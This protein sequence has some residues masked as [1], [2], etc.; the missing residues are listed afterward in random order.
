MCA[1]LVGLA[2]VNVL[3]V[4]L[5]VPIRVHV[6]TVGE[7]PGCEACGATALVKDRPVVELVDLSC[8]GRPTRLVWHKRRWCCVNEA[9]SLIHI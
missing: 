8:F 4:E 9:L 6:E 5:N 3:G 1:L 2:D 7:Y